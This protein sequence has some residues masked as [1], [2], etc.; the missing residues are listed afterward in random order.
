[1]KKKACVACLQVDIFNYSLQFITVSEKPKSVKIFKFSEQ[2]SKF[3]TNQ[4]N[5]IL[6]NSNDPVHLLIAKQICIL[7]LFLSQIESEDLKVLL[8]PESK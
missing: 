3:K 2:Q 7:I 8:R 1:M 5:L 4:K 6:I